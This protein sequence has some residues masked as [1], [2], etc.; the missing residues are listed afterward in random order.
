MAALLILAGLLMIA[1]GV[2][3]L[4][5]LAFQVSLLWGV[6]SLFPPVLLL[7]I[8]RCW[9]V[10]RKAVV[11]S[12]L[13]VVPLVAGYTQLSSEQPERAVALLS[14][15][16][17]Q[18]ISGVQEV[19]PISL[20]GELYGKAFNPNYGA[21]FDGVLVLREGDDLFAQRE[22]R[23]SLPPSLIV[24]QPTALRLDVLPGDIGELPEIEIRWLQPEQGL[25][26]AR[27]INRAYSLHM[28]LQREP[29][30]QLQGSFHLV[31]PRQFKTSISGEVRLQTDHLHYSDGQVD[32]HFDNSSTLEY[33]LKDFYQRRYKNA[34]V[35]LEPLPKTA[36]IVA[37]L[38]LQVTTWID[39]VSRSESV[40]MLK[41]A[42]HG[43]HVLGDQYP[44]WV[45][46][47]VQSIA[48]T[49]ASAQLVDQPEKT[50]VDRR[51][52]FSL[53][54]L[55]ANPLHYQRLQVHVRTVQGNQVEGQFMGLDE[56]GALLISR[57]VQAPGRVTFT[58]L[59][60]EIATITLLQP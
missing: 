12:A 18:G 36:E 8:V 41:S 11:F 50:V 13:G 40:R 14:L 42:E 30:N 7:F 35:R 2:L 34:Q 9:A 37:P 20:N 38:E 29:T 56:R 52:G 33:V 55:V 22:L 43:W 45:K 6:G 15:V 16:W 48:E 3:W 19:D 60:A 28:D 44:Q 24:E 54:Q 59:P 4:V 57:A 27:R 51:A 1:L 47:S 21:L 53:Q 49:A 31:L 5:A 46:P 26:E 58:L 23:I 32:R 17:L 10:A 25:P 39:G